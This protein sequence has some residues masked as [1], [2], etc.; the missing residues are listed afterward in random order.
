MPLVQAV[1][2]YYSGVSDALVADDSL[3]K[4]A[5]ANDGK[6]EYPLYTKIRWL[7]VI[8]WIVSTL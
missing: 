2:K 1:H 8:Q 3:P 7:N 6:I 5:A 4:P